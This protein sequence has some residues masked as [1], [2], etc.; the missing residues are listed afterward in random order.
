VLAVLLALAPSAASAYVP[1]TTAKTQ[2]ALR[3]LGSNCVQ[4]RINAV[5]SDD[6]PDG[7]EN[8]AARRAIDN[9]HKVIGSCSYLRFQVLEPDKPDAV[10][11]FD[12]K[13]PNE[14]VIVWVES[15]WKHDAQAAALTTVFFIEKEGAANDGQILDADIELNGERFRFT[16]TG[17][18]DRTDVENTVTHELGHLAGLDHPCNDGSR[19]PIPKDNAGATIPSCFPALKLPA[20]MKETTMYNFADPG[21]TKKRSPEADD[22]AGLCESYPLANDPKSCGPPDYS[23]DSGGCAI[24]EE[25]RAAGA[26]GAALAWALVAA[27]LLAARRRR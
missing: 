19:T 3:W 13:G 27:V 10:A 22:I 25:R 7:S 5:G 24:G 17:A 20:A 26:T 21:E 18:A 11:A 14:N 1:S 6:I 15:G 16:T 4:I 23:Q 12:K 9:W 2:K 8:A